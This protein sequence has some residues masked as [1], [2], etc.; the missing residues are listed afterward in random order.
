MYTQ[1]VVVFKSLARNLVSEI[2]L[3]WE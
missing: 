3:L 2:F 1:L